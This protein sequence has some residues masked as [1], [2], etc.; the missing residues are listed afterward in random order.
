MD[1]S[2]IGKFKALES[3]SNWVK[4]IKILSRPQWLVLYRAS[5][6]LMLVLQLR[7]QHTQ[8]EMYS[9]GVS[10]LVILR[11]NALM[12]YVII[13][14]LPHASEMAIRFVLLYLHMDIQ[15]SCSNIL[16]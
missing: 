4:T 15:L 2:F 12:N 3:D 6:I 1:A 5:P 11:L 8:M 14:F 7:W 13:A 9:P 10:I 16:E